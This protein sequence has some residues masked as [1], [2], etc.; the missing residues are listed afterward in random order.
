MSFHGDHLRKDILAHFN[1][2]CLVNGLF[3]VKGLRMRGSLVKLPGL[4]KAV[5][6]MV[7]WPGI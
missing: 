3:N 1:I 5:T 2:F 7:T 6:K 4:V